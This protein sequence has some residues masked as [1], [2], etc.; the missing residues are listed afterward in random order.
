M[1]LINNQNFLAYQLR[2]F[3]LLF[4]FPSLFSCHLLSGK[5]WS[6]HSTCH[7]PSNAACSPKLLGIANGLS[8]ITPSFS[9]H[10]HSVESCS[11][12]NSQL[13]NILFCELSSSYTDIHTCPL[14]GYSS[15]THF[16][17]HI[18]VC[19]HI[20]NSFV[21]YNN[22]GTSLSPLTNSEFL[23]S[24]YGFSFIFIVP[25]LTVTVPLGCSIIFVFYWIYIWINH[26]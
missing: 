1:P 23:D 14:V 2:Y 7:Y 22:C 26:V 21:T 6:S 11:T 9:I 13:I 25:D 24:R 4:I 17:V 12:A 18:E 20:N 8:L 16:S 5:L 19:A 3:L 10:V 15:V